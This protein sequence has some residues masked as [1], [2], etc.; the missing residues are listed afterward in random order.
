MNVW[1]AILTIVVAILGSSGLCSIILYRMQRK[2][3]KND[4][5][6]SFK[7]EV[8]QEFQELKDSFAEVVKRLE[9]SEKDNL[10]LQM[11]VLMDKDGEDISELMMVAEHYF[12]IGGDWYMTTMFNKW[13]IKNDIA[14][15]Q[16]FNSVKE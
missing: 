7:T 6:A 16:W 4:D 5:K 1:Q 15:P 2:D 9:R 3:K 8:K 11:L 10:R 13:L 12:D 14:N